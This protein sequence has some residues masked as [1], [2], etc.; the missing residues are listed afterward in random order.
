[1]QTVFRAGLS[2]LLASFPCAVIG[3][4]TYQVIAVS[5]EPAPGTN[6]TFR[7][8]SNPV[9]NAS[10]NVAF[11]ANLSGPTMHVA[12]HGISAGSRAALQQLAVAGQEASGT[13]GA[14]F[15]SVGWP[16]ILTSTGQTL[17]YAQLLHEKGVTS[18]NDYGIWIADPDDVRLLARTPDPAPGLPPGA[19]YQLFFAN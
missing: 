8:F 7:S 6:A 12:P 19:N 4:V 17:F 16:N 10:G 2:A 3:Q 9:I 1:M 18:D 14:R 11:Q 13:G 5:D 15:R